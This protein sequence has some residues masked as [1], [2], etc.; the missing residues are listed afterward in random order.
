[1]FHRKIHLKYTRR[2]KTSTVG[3]TSHRSTVHTWKNHL[4]KFKKSDIRQQLN[5]TV[6]T[7]QHEQTVHIMAD[8]AVV[9]L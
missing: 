1:M 5:F 8:G 4:N 7:T 2:V 3:I 9:T 6:R